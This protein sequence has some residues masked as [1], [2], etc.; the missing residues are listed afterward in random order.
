MLSGNRQGIGQSGVAGPGTARVCTPHLRI[1]EFQAFKTKCTWSSLPFKIRA[2]LLHVVLSPVYCFSGR[3]IFQFLKCAEQ[4]FSSS[5]C[6]GRTHWLE[7]FSPDSP[8]CPCPLLDTHSLLLPS[9]HLHGFLWKY[10]VVVGKDL[11]HI[12]GYKWLKSGRKH[13]AFFSPHIFT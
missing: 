6:A 9:V 5:L 8:C 10:T 4:F 3:M 7:S 2:P 12:R 11:I 13:R 1:F